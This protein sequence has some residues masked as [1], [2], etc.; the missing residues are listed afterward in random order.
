MDSLLV[1]KLFVPPTRPGLVP[2]PRLVERLK[3][4]LSF[5]L[6]LVSAPAGFGKTTILSQWSSETKPR[7]A[8]ISLDEGDNEPTRFW[9]Y[10][11][12]AM[13]S[14]HPASGETA[15]GLL[16]ATQPQPTESVLTSLIN[17]LATNT[18]AFAVVLDDYHLIKTEAIH[19]GVAFLLEHLPTNMHLVIATRA[20]PALPLAR[21]RARG[22][23][24]E[25]R[26]NDLRFTLDEATGLLE[27]MLGGA[28]SSADIGALNARTE[29]WA[30]GLKMAAL[31]LRGQHDIGSFLKSFTGSQ[32]YIMDYLVE[33][34]LTSQPQD[35]RDFLLTTSVLE[36]LSAPLCDFMTGHKGSQEMLANLE[37]R[38]LFFVPLDDS[39]EW[40]RY[41]HLFAELLRHQLEV[42][43][44]SQAVMALH[45]QACQWYE[46]S[47]Y[48]D[49]A[50]HHALAARDW[51]R[52][53]RLI[54]NLADSLINRAE[55]ST[56]LRWLQE[57]P[58]EIL[59]TYSRLYSRY[60]CMLASFGEFGSAE[61]ALGYLERMAQSDAGLH[62]FVAFGE[63]MLARRRGDIPHATEMMEEALSLVPPDDL[64]FRARTSLNLG[65]FRYNLGLFEEARRFF[66]DAYE[67]GRQAG[68]WFSGTSGA[69]YLGLI[70]RQKGKL[71]EALE[72]AHRAID[73]AGPSPA[74][75]I[76]RSLL[77]AVLLER[78]DLD[79]VARTAQLAAQLS[80]IGGAA[81]VRIDAHY[82]LARKRLVEGD[83][84]GAVT[85]ME[86]LDQEA[87]HPSVTPTF[88]AY[89]AAYHV[90]FAVRQDDLVTA[91]D[92][93]SRL[94]EYAG[95]LPFDLRHIPARLLIARGDK[96]AAMEQLKACYA[97]ATQLDAQGLMIGIRVYQTL[98]AATPEEALTFLVEAL[99]MGQPEGYIRTFVDEGKLLKPLLRK[100]FGQGITPEY[101][102]KL[103]DTV[104][105]EELRHRLATSGTGPKDRQSGLLSEREL[106]ILNLLAAGLSNR[107]IADRLMVTPG[108]V[109]VHV[110]NLME[111]LNARSR[112][113]AVARAREIGLT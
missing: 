98:A 22:A 18:Q 33:E 101:T 13:R 58:D 64:S 14:L 63:A 41:H 7:V 34:V 23:M 43:S 16:H 19:S 5:D 42:K 102:A 57:I 59:R 87:C 24:L 15:L 44:G 36:R 86:T 27:E 68:D 79:G 40:Y 45:R 73:L 60:C 62:G 31:S 83:V 32:R 35:V 75:A 66:I 95:V 110:H 81:A 25:I 6:T 11:I 52:A 49:D 80:A 69:G 9:Y 12:A 46:D 4:G 103:L 48:I 99:K 70:L 94:Q 74:S 30:V 93:G 96:A 90:I 61:A 8:W 50:I 71:R 38:N 104:E 97:K 72:M 105:A 26:E 10:F 106:E 56:L 53:I 100:A 82:W 51:E 2:R 76:P 20:D 84:A 28:V 112:S 67:M 55:W 3:S 91:S 77:A 88:R 109:K 92:W 29:G 111:K 108:T 21:F 54:G 89:Q 78:N 85:E 17:D 1:T 37:Q 39:R 107:Q 65:M 113:Q 47:N